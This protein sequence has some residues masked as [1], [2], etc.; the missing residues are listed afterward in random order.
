MLIPLRDKLR[1]RHL[2]VVILLLIVTNI[3]IFIRELL[4]GPELGR[5]FSNTQLSHLHICNP[6]RLQSRRWCR[7]I[8]PHL[9]PYF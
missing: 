2:P 5:F 6:G 1:S 3:Y 9:A 4:L 8:S 7:K